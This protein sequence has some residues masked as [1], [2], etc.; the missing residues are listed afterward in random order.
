MLIIFTISLAVLIY[1]ICQELDRPLTAT[2]DLEGHCPGCSSLVESGW[3]VCP[4]CRQLLRQT[5]SDCGRVHDNW[6][7]H[8]PWCGITTGDLRK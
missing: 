2:A 1:Y 4:R 5:C 6:V 8:C 7:Q 3:L